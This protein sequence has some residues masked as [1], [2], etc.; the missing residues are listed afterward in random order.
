[1][2]EAEKE[3]KHIGLLVAPAVNPF[4]GM[5]RVA[6]RLKCSNLVTGVSPR[7]AAEEL[8][9]RIGLAWEE[10][11]EPRHPFTLTLIRPD[12]PPLRVDLG[13][14]PPRL[15]PDDVARVHE[16]WLRL[17]RDE[18]LGSSLHHRDVVAESLRR[19]ESELETGYESIVA[20]LRRRIGKN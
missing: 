6:A 17:S 18:R 20:N 8:S 19:L 5:V 11:P 15:W 14:H 1:M 4:D 2:E 12:Q 10:L 9:R 13:P 16:L 7:M 3:G